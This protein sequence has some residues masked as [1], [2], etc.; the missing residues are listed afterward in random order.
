MSEKRGETR[1]PKGPLNF[2]P[3]VLDSGE[4]LLFGVENLSSTGMQVRILDPEAPALP[5]PGRQASFADCPEDLRRDFQKIKEI[6]ISDLP[7]PLRR[8]LIDRKAEVVWREGLLCGLRFAPPLEVSTENLRQ[9]M[10]TILPDG[11]G[12]AFDEFAG[13]PGAGE[14]AGHGRV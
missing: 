10:E 13:A 8:A 3:L 1:V 4:E 5:E 6:V 11:E 7:A 12:V 14:G 9:I 2:F